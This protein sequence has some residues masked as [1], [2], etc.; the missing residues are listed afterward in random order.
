LCGARCPTFDDDASS[1]TNIKV[2][3][4][5]D[6]KVEEDIY[7][8]E[9]VDVDIKEEEGENIKEAEDV[10]IKQEKCAIDVILP[11]VEAEKDEVSYITIVSSPFVYLK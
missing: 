1:V 3:G 5:I 8:K 2:E 9:E 7:V 11:E 6:I 4:D 10:D